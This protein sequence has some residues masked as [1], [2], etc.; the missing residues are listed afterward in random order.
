MSL[1][2]CL[3]K[4]V[5]VYIPVG[6]DK[7]DCPFC[8]TGVLARNSNIEKTLR[9][10]EAYQCDTCARPFIEGIYMSFHG[11]SRTPRRFFLEAPDFFYDD[12]Y[13]TQCRA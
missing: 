5:M 11:I 2:T 4:K 1:A 12:I 10:P 7:G 8:I 9:V 6:A 3:D 13:V